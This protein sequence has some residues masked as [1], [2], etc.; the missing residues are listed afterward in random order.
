[1]NAEAA[2]EEERQTDRVEPEMRRLQGTRTGSVNFIVYWSPESLQ[3]RVPEPVGHG[4]RVAVDQGSWDVTHLLE[5]FREERKG[6]ISN[7][8]AAVSKAPR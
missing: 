2:Q 4:A 8:L 6:Q 7:A 5:G 3:Q 1:M